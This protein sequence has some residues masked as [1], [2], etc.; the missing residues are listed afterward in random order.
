MASPYSFIYMNEYGLAIYGKTLGEIT[1]T[2]YGSISIYP[3][4]TEYDP[5]FA[6]EN[7]FETGVLYH[8]PTKRYYKGIA[9]YFLDKDNNK[10]GYIISSMDV[11]E[12]QTAKI[13]AVE[14]S[15]AKGDFLSNMSHE[16]RTPLNAIIGMTSMG[17]NANEIGRKDY[18]LGKI[19]EASK[20]LLGVINDI[21]DM[22]KIEAN[23]LELSMTKFVFE[24][25]LQRVV[26]VVNFKMEEK[27][28]LF[29]IHVD[30]NI[31]FMIIN[32]EQRLT[33]VIANLLSNATK[34]TPEHGSIRLDAR[35][36]D[37]KNGLCTIQI[38][39]TD[40]GI[41]ITEEQ[42]PRLFKV[43]EQA[44]RSTSRKFGGTGLGLVISKRIVEMMDG[45]IWI[46][47][48]PGKG[49][50]FSFTIMAQRGEENRNSMLL[51]GVNWKNVRIL[52][53]DD[54]PDV[55]DY[56]IDAAKQFSIN[57]D[58][59][60]SGGEALELINRN[61]SYDL[62]FID[63]KMPGMNGTELARKINEDNEKKHVIILISSTDLINIEAEA[64]EAGVNKFIQKPLFMSTIADCINECLGIEERKKSETDLGCFEGFRVLLAEDIEINREI[65]MALLEPT[66]L[67]IDCAEN[68]AEAVKLFSENSDRYDIIFM[69]LQMP[70]VDGFEAT[71]RI[72]ALEA[73]RNNG[74]ELP[75]QP[76]GIPII[77]MTANVFKEDI[78][79]C[80]AAGMNDHVGKPL[81][82]EE[83]MEKL[84]KH[85]PESPKYTE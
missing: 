20:H 12:I 63:W 2:Q 22:S 73:E 10:T 15:R 64:R 6:L 45:R 27:H 81:D 51:P 52:T 70:E 37:E 32:D 84:R 7:E 85:L 42:K 40:T 57:C 61:G 38:D 69:D 53:V 5:I 43:F 34:F 79:H 60:A 3:E 29:T 74:P 36:I 67:Q 28:Q 49:S 55:L 56:F 76:N 77:A 59:C 24:K 21:L 16:I 8:E 54:D 31:P 26:D 4:G 46:N 68:G 75:E 17:S 23:K 25:M 82:L 14:A 39:V 33:Q 72:R 65:V 44:E 48:E 83:V 62:Y 11:T 66:R 80:L 41:G 1:G 78:E 35:L 50:V 47:S 71:R 30:R 9:N 13:E 19:S 58:V 18:C